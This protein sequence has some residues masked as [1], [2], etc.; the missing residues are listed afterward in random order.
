MPGLREEEAE[1]R[2]SAGDV[3]R[4]APMKRESDFCWNFHGDGAVVGFPVP[5]YRLSSSVRGHCREIRAN[6]SM[7][8][9]STRLIDLEVRDAWLER[10]A[11]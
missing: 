3:L 7:R 2:A 9:V 10:D 8:I 1:S 4:A 6:R 5:F 11:G